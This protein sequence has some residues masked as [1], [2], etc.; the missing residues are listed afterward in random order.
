VLTAFKQEFS[1][2]IFNV[3]K[4]AFLSKNIG[5]IPPHI[6]A[7]LPRKENTGYYKNVALKSPQI[8]KW[9]FLYP[10]VKLAR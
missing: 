8:N 3:T 1:T 6:D 10:P 9:S 2:V 4:I 5:N 7:F